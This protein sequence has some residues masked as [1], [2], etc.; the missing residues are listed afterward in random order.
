MGSEKS[1][2]VADWSL[3]P[4]DPVAFFDLPPEFERKTLKRRYNQFLR[5]FKPEK[6]PAEFQKIRAAYELL[7]GQLRYGASQQSDPSAFQWSSS[8]PSS[9][10]SPTDA[11]NIEGRSAAAE[12]T[13]PIHQRIEKESV[14]EIF[15]ELRERRG[16]SP[17][18]Y[19]AMALLSD[20]ATDDPS[21]FFKLILTGL[22]KHPEEHGL[23]NLLYEYLQQ[24]IKPKQIPGVLKAVSQVVTN[25]YFYFLTEKIWDVYLRQVEF[26]TWA[27]LLEICE[28][29]LKDFRIT[30][31]LAFYLHILPAAI[32]KGDPKWIMSKFD[33][34]NQAG[35]DVPRELETDLELVHQLLEYRRSTAK[36]QSWSQEIHRAIACYFL[37]AG[38]KGD[39]AVI[40]LQTY[41]AQNPR[42]L[43]DSYGPDQAYND[44]QLSIWD[45]VNDEVCQRHDLS[46]SMD[47][48]QLRARIF[49]LMDD[50]NRSEY[51]SFGWKEELRYRWMQYG[52]YTIA[53]ATPLILLSAWFE[54]SMV[55]FVAIVLAIAGVLVVRFL[56]RPADRYEKY[57]ERRMR[58]RYFSDWRGRFVH[59]FEATHMH[60]YDVSQALIEIVEHHS[61]KVQFASWLC[62]YLPADVG[63]HLFAS[64]SRYM[65]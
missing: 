4:H 54:H 30:G 56:Y 49:D 7:D 55:I 61:D 44:L 47:P 40:A 18:D 51:A 11:E 59:L 43:L 52:T 24:D 41:Y 17:F 23:M 36:D 50:L 48:R 42:V 20:V 32:F 37:Q 5:Q 28:S 53:I 6:F 58:N 22:Q 14:E 34:L 63:L 21:M 46:S 60:H 64:S 16:K 8:K 13:V 35:T 27:R 9:H 26:D 39:E 65:Q 62:H 12:I 3:L 38:R 19:F 2:P 57:I 25:Q 33:L 31:Q 45:Y 1:Q 15:S 10:G 29:N